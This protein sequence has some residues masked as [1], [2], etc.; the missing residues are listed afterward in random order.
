MKVRLQIAIWIALASSLLACTRGRSSDEPETEQLT[1]EISTSPSV[2]EMPAPTNPLPSN[3]SGSMVVYTCD[4]GT[5]LTVTYEK[6]SALVKLPAGATMLSRA[7]STSVAYDE[8][9]LGEELSLFRTGG[10]VQLQVSG[11]ARNCVRALG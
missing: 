3:S 9:Y 11:K 8:A 2:L 5:G 4:D 7:E 6:H 10:M 1:K